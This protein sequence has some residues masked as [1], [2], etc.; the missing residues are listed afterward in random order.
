[1]TSPS[2]SLPPGGAP[3]VPPVVTDELHAKIDRLRTHLRGLDGVIIGFSGGVDS[4][5]L[6]KIAY[7]ELGDRCIALTAVSPSLPARERGAAAELAKGIGVRHELRESS[8]IHNPAYRD[9]PTNRCYFCKSA[10]FMLARELK[11]ET[12]IE[13]VAIGTNLDDLKGHRPGMKAAT[14]F[15]ALHPLVTAEFTKADVRAASKLAG[16]GTWDKQEFACLSS[17]FPYG[18]R[19]DEERLLRV[20]VCE[21]VLARLGFQV[22]RVRYHGPVVRIELGPDEIARAMEAS[23]RGEIVTGCKAAGFKYVSLDLEGYRRGS[24]NE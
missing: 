9:N 13:T 2:P 24:M 23:V 12:G 4:A 11:A 16:L 18:T 14:E 3:R 20:E 19:I 8:E 22:Y 7:E 17:R 15:G 5:Y 1:V 21:D 6:L 10:L